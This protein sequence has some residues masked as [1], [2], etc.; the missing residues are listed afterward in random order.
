MHS[1]P[2]LTIT[3]LAC[4]V[5]LAAPATAQQMYKYVDSNGKTVYTDKI[6]AADAGRAAEQLSQQGTVLKRIAA[7]LTPEQRAALE[8]ERKRKIEADVRA[9]EERR[10]NMALLNTY[11]SEADIDQ[12]HTRALRAN[13]EAIKDAERKFADAQKRQQQLKVDAE[14]YQKKQLPAQLKRDIQANEF[15][16]KAQ[17][18]LLDAKRKE[19]ALISARYNDDKK[20]YAEL[21]KAGATSGAAAGTTVSSR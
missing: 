16:L 18:E 12:A 15:E 3:M 21:I 19:I 17:A 8:E 14:F 10:K 9:K 5:F 11:S 7:P 6:P 2:T 20:R 1:A 13:D 4:A